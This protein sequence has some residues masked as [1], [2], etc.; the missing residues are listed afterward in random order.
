MN[1]YQSTITSSTKIPISNSKILLVN[2]TLSEA[3]ES[4]HTTMNEDGD[5]LEIC[6]LLDVEHVIFSSVKRFLSHQ[7]NLV[8]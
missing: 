2:T 8:K 6:T 7:S 3:C 1:L 5:N 4:A